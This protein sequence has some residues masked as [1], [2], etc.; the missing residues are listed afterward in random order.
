[1][2]GQEKSGY[3]INQFDAKLKAIKTNLTPALWAVKQ[4]R[5]LNGCWR[6]FSC[7]LFGRCVLFLRHSIEKRS[8]SDHDLLILL[9]D[10]LRS[11]LIFIALQ[12]YLCSHLPMSML[13]FQCFTKLSHTK[14]ETFHLQVSFLSD[15]SSR[16]YF[17]QLLSLY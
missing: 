10:N 11:I 5:A 7:L 13:W 2:I 4:L 12:C 14:S 17:W 3:V 1:M 9:F 15:F 16:M 6:H 8:K